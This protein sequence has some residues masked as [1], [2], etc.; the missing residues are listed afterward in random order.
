MRQ[1]LDS[2]WEHQADLSFSQAGM[3]DK[4]LTKAVLQILFIYFREENY[5]ENV[6][7][8]VLVSGTF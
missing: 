6:L 1:V 4:K 5:F 3:G 8:I 7:K 2:L